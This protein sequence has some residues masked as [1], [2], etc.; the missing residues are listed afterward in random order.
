[1]EPPEHA[2]KSKSP[3]KSKNPKRIA[4]AVR[5]WEREVLFVQFLCAGEDPQYDTIDLANG[6]RKLD[7]QSPCPGILLIWT[8]PACDSRLQPM[9]RRVSETCEHPLGTRL[10]R[11][12]ILQPPEIAFTSPVKLHGRSRRTACDAWD[13]CWKAVPGIVARK[14]EFANQERDYSGEFFNGGENGR[15]RHLP[16][17][18]VFFG[19]ESR[20]LRG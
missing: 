13:K 8:Y 9:A 18:L 1:M 7:R 4:V 5:H 3:D 12:G 6:G 17:G 20:L 14:R 10:S 16:D 11:T 2:F 19:V 15:L